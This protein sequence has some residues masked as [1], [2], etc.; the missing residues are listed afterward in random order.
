MKKLT[1]VILCL[2]LCCGLAAT[3]FARYTDIDY[4]YASAKRSSG[5]EIYCRAQL[6][7]YNDQDLEIEVIVTDSKGNEI[8]TRS[9]SVYDNN[10]SMSEYIKVPG[11]GTYTCKFTYICGV[12]SPSVTRTVKV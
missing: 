12:D 8:D 5:T 10:L 6:F 1:C 11:S 9:V 7:A 4:L 2:A 3:S